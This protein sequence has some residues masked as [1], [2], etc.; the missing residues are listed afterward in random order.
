MVELVENKSENKHVKSCL[1]KKKHQS[2]K[3]ICHIHHP[4]EPLNGINYESYF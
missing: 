3:V 4:T 1:N 2:I